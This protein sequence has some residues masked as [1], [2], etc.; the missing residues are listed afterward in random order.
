MHDT[1]VEVGWKLRTLQRSRRFHTER[2]LVNVY[3]SR[4]LGYLEHR[5]PAVYHATSTT[6][7]PL[8]AVQDCFLRDAGLTQLEALMH[9]GCCH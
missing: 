6:L 9:N 4:V 3:K 8:D 1:V 2:E 5:T 7:Q